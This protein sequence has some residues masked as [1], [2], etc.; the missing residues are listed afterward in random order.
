MKPSSCGRPDARATPAGGG[1]ARVG[2]RDH[3]VRVD[4]R[5]APQDLAHPR[6]RH[7]E[8]GAGHLRVRAGEVDVLEHAERPAL[9]LR[10]DPRLDPALGQRHDL[11]GKDLAQVLGAD[12]LKRARLAGH[13]IGRATRL[14]LD[15]PQCQRTQAVGVAERDHRVLGHRHGRERALQT[16]Q[17]LGDGVLDPLG[18]MG[19]EQRGDDL[20]VR[21]G[22]ERDVAAAQLGVEL[23]GVDQ[24]AVVRERQRPMVVTDDRLGVLPLRGAGRGVAHM[25]DRHVADQRAQ[26]VLVEHLG[27][28]A[29]VAD[30]HQA[31]AALGGRDP[32]RLLAPVLQ[33]EQGEVRQSGDVV[34]RREDA[35]DTA[36]VAR[37]IA[38]IDHGFHAQPPRRLA[39]G[40]DELRQSELT[41]IAQLGNCERQLTVDGQLGPPDPADHRHLGQR[42]APDPR[43]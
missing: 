31:A 16:G 35:E 34:L 9:G 36:L 38:M 26:D 33:R 25:A 3:E 17:H 7:L 41:G 30:R 1:V 12:Q 39:A 22:A 40:L 14:V 27:D 24:V 18:G 28:Q 42:I 32:R 19:R 5:L 37:A 6:A 13:A 43:R 4:R 29:L 11:A 2:H 23:D 20:R 15:H 21:R 8:H 10:H